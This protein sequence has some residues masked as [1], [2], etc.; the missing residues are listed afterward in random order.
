MTAAA[1]AAKKGVGEA[2]GSKIF[3]FGIK[4]NEEEEN[5]EEE[6]AVFFNFMDLMEDPTVHA[7]DAQGFQE[8]MVIIGYIGGV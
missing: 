7:P 2:S 4:K 3:K 5:E 8:N 6:E 1:A